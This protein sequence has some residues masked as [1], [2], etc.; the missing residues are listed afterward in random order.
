[1]LSDQQQSKQRRVTKK[2]LPRMQR[3]CESNL[4][5]LPTHAWLVSLC[6][7]CWHMAL[8]VP[9]QLHATSITP[10]KEKTE[11]TKLDD[12]NGHLASYTD[13]TQ[14]RA[15][16]SEMD[17]NSLELTRRTWSSQIPHQKVRILGVL[18][19]SQVGA[20]G[21]RNKYQSLTYC[22]YS[23]PYQ[24]HLLF[25]HIPSASSSFWIC[26]STGWIFRKSRWLLLRSCSKCR[27]LKGQPV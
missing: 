16:T 19:C 18:I 2:G 4:S 8:V 9:T 10:L 11:I 24:S 13:S 5:L 25:C 6:K 12:T 7:G 1:M 17:V 23:S 20:P 14:P 22:M 3:V 27:D 15:T 21:A 26:F